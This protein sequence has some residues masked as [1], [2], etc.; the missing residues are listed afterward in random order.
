[1]TICTNIIKYIFELNT[2]CKEPDLIGLVNLFL[3]NL[4]NLFVIPRTISV[5]INILLYN[6]Y[7]I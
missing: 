5:I 4:Q 7:N 3:K 6:A 1:M 2:E